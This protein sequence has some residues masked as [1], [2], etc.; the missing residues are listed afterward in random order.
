M[1]HK[2]KYIFNDLNNA[3]YMSNTHKIESDI[4]S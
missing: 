4:H 2:V 3:I 1:S